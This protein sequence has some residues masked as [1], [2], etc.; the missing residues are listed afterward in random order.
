MQSDAQLADIFERHG[1][2]VYVVGKALVTLRR[3]NKLVPQI[4]ELVLEFWQSTLNIELAKR[5]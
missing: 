5:F 1:R 4:A 3:G 2:N